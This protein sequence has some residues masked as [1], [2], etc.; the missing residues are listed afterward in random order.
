MTL[1]SCTL[2]KN[3]TI[4]WPESV[5]TMLCPFSFKSA[6]QSYNILEMYEDGKIPDQNFS[7]M[8]FQNFPTKYHSW[9]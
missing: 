1:G 5:I 6:Y 4:S 8:E 2:L 7:G 3:A 9:G